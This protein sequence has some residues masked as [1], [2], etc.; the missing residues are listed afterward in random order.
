MSGP[1][2][3]LALSPSSAIA[4]TTAA[5]RAVAGVC[6][7]VAI[8]VDHYDAALGGQH[9][10]T[11]DLRHHGLH[12]GLD[13]AFDLDHHALDGDARLVELDTALSDFQLDGLHGFRLALAGVELGG[14]V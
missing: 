11:A 10:G 4:A 3:A 6:G 9:G 14:L 5:G 12:F 8:S 1:S 2:R 13:L 7:C